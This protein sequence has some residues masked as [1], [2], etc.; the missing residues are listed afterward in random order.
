MP[1]QD[2]VYFSYLPTIP[3]ECFDG[4]VEYKVTTDIFKRVRATLEAKTDKTIYYNYQIP[5]GETPEIVAYKYYGDTRYHWVILLMNSIK[6]P[7]WDWP[8]NVRSFEKF[9]TKKYGVLLVP[10]LVKKFSVAKHTLN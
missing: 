5:E 10:I 2:G 9:I 4:S 6:N 3:Y 8:L 7:Q 1:Y